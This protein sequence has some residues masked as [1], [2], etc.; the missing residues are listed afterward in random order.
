LSLFWNKVVSV[1]YLFERMIPLGSS[2]LR[3]QHTIH[4]IHAQVANIPAVIHTYITIVVVLTP[5]L[6]VSGGDTVVEA[7]KIPT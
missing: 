4:A 3:Q 2:R 7:E 5:S 6:M 1:L